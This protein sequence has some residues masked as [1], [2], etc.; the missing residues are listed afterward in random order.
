MQSNYRIYIWD[1]FRYWLEHQSV[2]SGK[3]PDA[4][5]ASS[6]SSHEEGSSSAR[7]IFKGSYSS[8]RSRKI[9]IKSYLSTTLNIILYYKICMC[10]YIF[11]NLGWNIPNQ[12][13][14]VR[15]VFTFNW[16]LITIMRK[17]YK[18]K[19]STIILVFIWQTVT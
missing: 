12:H 9:R 7:R 4:C 8:T 11:N 17:N 1:N 13:I 3:T 19:T 10:I 15:C 2:M 14:C 5:F 6:D 18:F 16:Y